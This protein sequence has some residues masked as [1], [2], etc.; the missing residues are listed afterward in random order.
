MSST[1]RGQPIH[2]LVR[3]SF[4]YEPNQNDGKNLW[5]ANLRRPLVHFP[6]TVEGSSVEYTKSKF[7][8][9]LGLMGILFGF[10]FA[11]IL[12]PALSPYFNAGTY[13][14][15]SAGI[16]VGLIHSKITRGHFFPSRADRANA[17]STSRILRHLA[18]W[19]AW[20]LFVF[21]VL[22]LFDRWMKYKPVR[23]PP[24]DVN[25][26]ILPSARP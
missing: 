13:A 25:V 9:A 2:L 7:K 8:L 10:Q 17:P 5:G 4:D 3:S 1:R 20:I 15:A 11:A 21:V 23:W 6:R 12:I 26:N 14:I 18:G 16:I 24:P 19:T 22:L